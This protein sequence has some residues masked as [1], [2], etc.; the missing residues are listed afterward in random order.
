MEGAMRDPVPD[1]V[2]GVQTV[3]ACL[4]EACFSAPS[5]LSSQLLEAAN[6][7]HRS[8]PLIPFSPD[9]YVTCLSDRDIG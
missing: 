5:P 8:W 7:N 1:Q 6:D 9:W 3:I 4:E 2:D